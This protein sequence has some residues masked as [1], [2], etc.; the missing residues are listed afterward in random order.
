[1]GQEPEGMPVRGPGRRRVAQFDPALFFILLGIFLS[2]FEF[3]DLNPVRTEALFGG[4]HGSPIR[5]PHYAFILALLCYLGSVRTLRLSKLLP[6]W[7]MALFLVFGVISTVTADVPGQSVNG[8][9]KYIYFLFMVL[10]LAMAV[11]STEERVRLAV[12]AAM[13]GV[14]GNFLAS[15]YVYI[16]VG[17]ITAAGVPRAWF[18]EFYG[19]GGLSFAALLGTGLFL[20][21][22]KGYL[23]SKAFFRSVL[24]LGLGSAAV[25]L[26]LLT[27]D[28]AAAGALFIGLLVVTVLP[29]TGRV[30]FGRVALRTLIVSAV[31]VSVLVFG[32]QLILPEEYIRLF[33]DVFTDPFADQTLR[34]RFEV[35]MAVIR[36]WPETFFSGWGFD[37]VN[38]SQPLE[39]YLAVPAESLLVVWPHNVFLSL[40]VQSGF[41]SVLLMGFI[42]LWTL[43][44]GWRGLKLSRPG[45]HSRWA[46]VGA[47]ASYFA[48]LAYFTLHTGQYR[49]IN[50]VS[51][52]LIYAMTAVLHERTSRLPAAPAAGPARVPHVAGG[53]HR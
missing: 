29:V 35:N 32:F 18:G 23:A 4:F 50:W 46:L 31:S 49:H 2:P 28:R 16:T 1:M 45:T 15:F 26:G 5:P 11:L 21:Y 48:V 42:I 25:I 3:F 14:I 53:G 24:M 44:V 7:G 20:A 27:L 39:R 43:Y 33:A 38:V 34:N 13:L 47:M 9:L 19:V 51:F 40:W 41:L 10:P 6:L 36:S 52:I 37:I 22:F 8:T 17:R 30:S 12:A